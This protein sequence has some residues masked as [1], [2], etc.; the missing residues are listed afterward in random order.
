MGIFMDVI[1]LSDCG[2][3]NFHA[4]FLS[5]SRILILS[6]FASA[7]LPFLPCSLPGTASANLLMPQ[8]FR[9]AP[10]G[11][12]ESLCSDVLGLELLTARASP[13]RITPHRAFPKLLAHVILFCDFGFGGGGGQGYRTK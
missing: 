11:S 8:S 10:L 2:I 7:C 4:F 13:E 3:L 6:V 12:H 1:V 5:Y 9:R